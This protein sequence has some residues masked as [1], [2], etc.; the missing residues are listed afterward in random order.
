MEKRDR[1]R[2]GKA[3]QQKIKWSVCLCLFIL[4]MNW[5][6][7]WVGTV[8]PLSLRHLPTFCSLFLFMTMKYYELQPGI[9]RL[10]VAPSRNA[11]NSPS[12]RLHCLSLISTQRSHPY[13]LFFSSL[14]SSTNSLSSESI[15]SFNSHVLCTNANAHTCDNFFSYNSGSTLPT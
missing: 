11:S 4:F 12:T 15:P 5:K 6:Y 1:Y 13:T 9:C 14:C 8:Q 7:L 2:C 10:S 3:R